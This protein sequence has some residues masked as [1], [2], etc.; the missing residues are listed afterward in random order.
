ML[1]S[2][3][4]MTEG[5]NGWPEEDDGKAVAD[6]TGVERPNPSPFRRI[7]E[8]HAQCCGTFAGTAALFRRRIHI[9]AAVILLIL[10]T[11]KR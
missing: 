4:C 11:G 6:T 5:K 3:A 8:K 9:L 2:A 10:Q 1:C 7:R